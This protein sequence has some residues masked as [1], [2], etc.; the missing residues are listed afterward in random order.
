MQPTERRASALGDERDLLLGGGLAACAVGELQR[1]DG[2][3]LAELLQKLLIRLAELD[4]DRG[5]GLGRE[6]RR[7]RGELH[8]LLLRGNLLLRGD[9]ALGL[10]GEGVLVRQLQVA[11]A[12]LEGEVLARGA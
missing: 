2:R 5:L 7:E 4:L 12:V 3:G 9:R 8:L 1:E 11:L 6:A 10:D